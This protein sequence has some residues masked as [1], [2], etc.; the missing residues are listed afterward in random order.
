MQIQDF[1]VRVICMMYNKTS[2][3]KN[4]QHVKKQA[5][6]A[7]TCSLAAIEPGSYLFKY[8]QQITP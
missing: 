3:G 5:V 6:V 2:D 8:K 7:K 1:E 4:N